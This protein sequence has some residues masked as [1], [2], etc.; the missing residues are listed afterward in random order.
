MDQDRGIFDETKRELA[1]RDAIESRLSALQNEL[2]SLQEQINA[3]NDYDTMAGACAT[4]WTHVRG[5]D[6]VHHELLTHEGER[7][8]ILTPDPSE[9][10]RECLTGAYAQVKRA[11]TEEHDV[12]IGKRRLHMAA[13]LARQA[14]EA[15]DAQFDALRKDER[16]RWG[17]SPEYR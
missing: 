5:V 15:L 8:G 4:S 3:V 7:S 9:V 14:L 16:D 17:R 11:M 6:L 13:G 10:T 12:E 2:L 1:E